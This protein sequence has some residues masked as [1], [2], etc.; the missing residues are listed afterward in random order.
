MSYQNCQPKSKDWDGYYCKR[1]IT[2]STAMN[3]RLLTAVFMLYLTSSVTAQD[4]YSALTWRRNTAYHEYLMRDVHHQYLNR[5][6]ELAEAWTSKD[7]MR[8]YQD[9]RRE[10]YRKIIGTFPQIGNLNGQILGNSEQNGFRIEKIMF[11]STPKRYVTANLYIP[12]GNGPFPVVVILC[13]HGIG[14][15]IP[16]PYTAVLLASNGIAAMVVDP[17]GQGERLELIDSNN[18]PLTR[19]VT[20]EHTLVNAGC[21][22]LGSNVAAYEY[23]DNHRAID[24][25]ETRP[26]IDKNNI[27][28]FGSSGGGTQTAYFV[29]LENRIKAASIGS[30]F[31]QR[32]RVLE[33]EGASDGC[34]HVPY[35][36]REGIEIADFA[37]MF[38]PKPMLILAGRYDFVDFW[39]VL[40][41]FEELEKSYEVLEGKGLVALSAVEAGH[42]GNHESQL[43][44][45]AFF[46]KH[47]TDD[48]SPVKD[49]QRI[50]LV[51]A[52]LQC[53]VTGQVKT[54]IPDAVS[55]CDYNIQLAGQYASKRADFMKQG[56]KVIR[57]KM[58][59][60]LGITLPKEKIT[61]EPT[62]FVSKR[63]YNL[64]K[65]Q[66]IRLGEM[67]VPCV[68]VVP[69]QVNA[70]EDVVLYLNEG[71]KDE[72]LN[73]EAQILSFV[74]RGSIVVA[75]DLRGF[76]ETADPADFNDAKY[77]NREYRNAMT[78][79]HI[80]R[81]VT[82]QRVI[83]IISLLDFIDS[84]AVTKGKKVRIAANGLYGPT[85]IHAAC[86]DKRIKSAEITRSI[87]S[88]TEY[89][90]NPM[91]RD[92]FTNV[93]YG[94]LQY[95]DLKDLVNG[96][97]KPVV[98]PP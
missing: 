84:D 24:Y 72:F 51:R 94:V 31:S 46:K 58:L 52:D 39:G 87:R 64:Y 53:T 75:A 22:L 61:A 54:S 18:V 69:E 6:K 77:W 37:L 7:K 21:N 63:T 14:G 33:L 89:I 49:V 23:W 30:Y 42:G 65:Y 29:G 5:E 40:R 10:S 66:V 20:T 71:G 4:N 78:G 67:P 11:E 25:L 43:A 15:K 96:M 91:Q 17:V 76:G 90:Q 98:L 34:Q 97:D 32:E 82:G 55:M 2:G 95:Y 12:D 35:E 59:E 57:A 62:G 92:A 38:A 68:V 45:A 81:P 80:G 9:K 26:D 44:L 48:H 8:Q 28:V 1:H 85:V 3:L 47:L 74:N 19:G 16:G 13:G 27:G 88:Y 60:L 56:E 86:L 93:L 73:D 50:E 70:K 79:M 36:G 41:G 83:D